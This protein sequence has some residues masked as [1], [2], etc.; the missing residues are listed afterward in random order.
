MTDPNSRGEQNAIYYAA[1]E[2]SGCTVYLENAGAK[3]DS[4]ATKNQLA[5]VVQTLAENGELDLSS[6][7]EGLGEDPAAN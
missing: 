5:E 3:A 6:Y 2:M 4:K 7:A 1:F